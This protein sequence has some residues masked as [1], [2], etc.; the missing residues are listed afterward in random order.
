MPDKKKKIAV[1]AQA[2]KLPGEKQGLDRIAYVSETLAAAGYDV[3]LYTSKFQHWDKEFREI[4]KKSYR[5]LPYKIMFLDEPGY[6]RNIDLKRVYSHYKLADSLSIALAESPVKYD[7]IYCLIPPNDLARTS[8]TYAKRN[9]IPLVVDVSDLWPEAMKMALNV[10]VLSDIAFLPFTLDA[11]NVYKSAAAVIGTS[12]EYASRPLKDNPDLDHVTVYVGNDLSRFDSAVSDADTLPYKEQDEFWVTYAGTL[13]KSYDI[14]TL[15]DA[16]VKAQPLVD[17]K[18][19]IKILG[20]GPDIQKFAAHA[21]Q[22]QAPVDFLG[23]VYYDEMCCYLS[24]SDVLVNSLVKGAPQSIVSKVAD[25]LA[26]AK[27]IINTGE[28]IEFKDKV[29]QDC[30]GINVEPQNVDELAAAIVALSQDRDA[31]MKMGENGRKIA[32][33][34]FDRPRAYKKIVELVDRLTGK[35][36]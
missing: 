19:R 3:T 4:W 11:K 6:S 13:G 14:D 25:Y 7:L 35:E 9:D 16:A 28:S 5:K 36:G 27:P 1:V 30:F 17:G 15:I 32:E 22:V 31:A 8:A 24:Q 18:L 20:D 34:Q 23:Y 10:P 2:V 21:K 29:E 33:E 12:D 26:A